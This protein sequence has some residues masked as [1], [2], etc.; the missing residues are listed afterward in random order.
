MFLSTLI[1]PWNSPVY[2][3]ISRSSHRHW[4]AP[5]RSH[6]LPFFPR[7]SSICCFALFFFF[8]R[9][10]LLSVDP[11]TNPP[12]HPPILLTPSFPPARAFV[13]CIF[14]FLP[15]GT[16]MGADGGRF[17]GHEPVRPRV[18]VHAHLQ[19]RPTGPQGNRRIVV[20]LPLH[21]AYRTIPLSVELVSR[22]SLPAA[23]C[24][25]F[26]QRVSA[27]RWRLQQF[28]C[29]EFVVEKRGSSSSSSRLLASGRATQ[30]DSFFLLFC[31]VDLE[32]GLGFGEPSRA[33]YLFTF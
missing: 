24:P 7:I 27:L 13:W 10:P 21:L 16:S 11:L 29:S 3:Y 2:I 12:T 30:L 8:L 18:Y 14:P 23:R 22:A 5:V 20:L 19:P 9:L 26:K 32:T 31:C 33:S 28:H 6:Y 1:S 4:F 17:A 15:G 25:T